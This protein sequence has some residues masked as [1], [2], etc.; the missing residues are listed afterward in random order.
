MGADG[1]DWFGRLRLATADTVC[2]SCRKIRAAWLCGTC[3]QQWVKPQIVMQ[4][5][6]LHAIIFSLQPLAG[7]LKKALYGAKFYQNRQA[8]WRCAGMLAMAMYRLQQAHAPAMRWAVTTIPPHEHHSRHWMQD[9]Q[10]L[11][12]LDAQLLPSPC[13]FW[14]RPTLRQHNLI[15]PEDRWLN[16]AESLRCEAPPVWPEAVLLLDDI[17]TTGASLHAAC[18]AIRAAGFKGVLRG[19]TLCFVPKPGLD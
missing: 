5:D 12:R 13:L 19:L 2:F 6:A 15:S 1:S 14:V 3:E 16:M 10:Q 8:H 11:I 18:R 9:I 7:S 4:W 17:T